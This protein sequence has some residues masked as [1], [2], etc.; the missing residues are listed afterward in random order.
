[1][2]QNFVKS[3]Q[4]SRKI[5]KKTL[6]TFPTVTFGLGKLVKSTYVL[7]LFTISG[8]YFLE[9][10]CISQRPV[11]FIITGKY[12]SNEKYLGQESC[13]TFFS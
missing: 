5:L 6:L 12:Y 1:M 11:F 10:F 13:D 7:N 9:T 3:A 4:S 2:T 8:A